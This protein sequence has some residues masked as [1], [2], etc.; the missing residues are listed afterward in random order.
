MGENYKSVLF[1]TPPQVC[2][3]STLGFTALDSL[4]VGS[5]GDR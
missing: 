4:P 3:L 5:Y 1:V 2:E